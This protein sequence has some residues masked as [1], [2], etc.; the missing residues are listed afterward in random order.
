[1]G[2]IDDGNLFSNEGC[3]KELEEKEMDA[4]EVKRYDWLTSGIMT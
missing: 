4:N 1:M 2:W 3:R